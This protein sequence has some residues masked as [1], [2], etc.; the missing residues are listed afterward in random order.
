MAASPSIKILPLPDL[1]RDPTLPTCIWDPMWEKPEVGTRMGM[2]AYQQLRFES[3]EFG[4]GP[5][6]AAET[7]PEHPKKRI[8]TRRFVLDV[9]HTFEGSATRLRAGS[10]GEVYKR[11]TFG[12]SSG[13]ASA[14]F[15]AQQLT[16]GADSDGRWFLKGV[17][18]RV[19]GGWGTRAGLVMRFVTRGGEV[20][21]GISCEHELDP[22]RDVPFQLLGRD[23]LLAKHFDQLH[24]ADLIFF[25]D[26]G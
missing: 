21:G 26:P 13:K 1:K 17:V 14:N 2:L 12:V 20:V 15:H 9:V 23:P 11:Y 8:E 16:F 6:L 19:D 7:L 3:A 4:A 5:L 25:S 18:G 24:Q 10:Y 22:P